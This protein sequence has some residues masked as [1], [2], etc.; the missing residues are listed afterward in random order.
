MQRYLAATDR[1]IEVTE[2]L[3][4]G[5]VGLMKEKAAQARPAQNPYVARIVQLW[6]TRGSR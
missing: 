3:K 1:A 5:I 2:D 6:R 4:L